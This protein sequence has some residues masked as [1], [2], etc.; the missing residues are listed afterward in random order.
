MLRM[1]VLHIA[2]VFCSLSFILE[3]VWMGYF[4][5]GAVVPP[6][7]LT[8]TPCHFF[9]S[10]VTVSPVMVWS[11]NNDHLLRM[12]TIVTHSRMRIMVEPAASPPHVLTL[13]LVLP[14]RTIELSLLTVHVYSLRCFTL[15]LTTLRWAF[16]KRGANS[17]LFE[18]MI[19]AWLL[20]S[21]W[22]S[23][24][25]QIL[26][27]LT[28]IPPSRVWLLFSRLRISFLISFPRL[29]HFCLNYSLLYSALLAPRLYLLLVWYLNFQ[30]LSSPP[31]NMYKTH[32]LHLGKRCLLG[33]TGTA[34]H[35]RL[36]K[37]CIYTKNKLT[38]PKSNI[39]IR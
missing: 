26:V 9:K 19:L 3:A 14:R 28:L 21:L 37:V 30:T 1:W 15:S 10:H 7:M 11:L 23:C 38:D 29:G 34:F 24:L 25:P 13:E 22:I 32:Q 12:L 8:L 35:Q 6:Q 17:F 39:I 31:L 20:L 2:L 36:S 27:A 16:R 18:N 4:R 33:Y 5:S